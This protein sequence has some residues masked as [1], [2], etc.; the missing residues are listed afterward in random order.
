MERNIQ[1]NG[2]VNLVIL[3]AVGLAAFAVARYANSL[4]GT[5]AAG[6]LGLGGLV[7]L[8]SWFQMRLEERE[9][10]EKLEFDEVT[11][12]GAITKTTVQIGAGY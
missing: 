4:A 1:K 9:R 12:G 6:F 7:A 11:K 8:V 10:I 3:L 5:V 2:L